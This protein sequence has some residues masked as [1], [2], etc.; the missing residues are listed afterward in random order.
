M[1]L[2]FPAFADIDFAVAHVGSVSDDEVVSEAVF[3]VT[4]FAVVAVHLLGGIDA[5]AAMMDDDVLPL[6]SLGSDVCE[7]ASDAGVEDGVL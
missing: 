4:L 6:V 5:R 3:H 7:L 1:Y 2:F